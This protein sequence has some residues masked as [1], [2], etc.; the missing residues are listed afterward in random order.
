MI[1]IAIVEEKGLTRVDP[2]SIF[3]GYEETDDRSS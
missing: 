1:V 2:F 3:G